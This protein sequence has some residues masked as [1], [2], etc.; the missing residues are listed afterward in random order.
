[1]SRRCCSG[2]RQRLALE[3]HVVGIG[4]RGAGVFGI[5]GRHAAVGLTHQYHV[6]Q[7]RL[8]RGLG[9][10][11]LL[12][13]NREDGG[14]DAAGRPRQA[15][16]VGHSG[17]PS[18]ALKCEHLRWCQCACRR[19]LIEPVLWRP[20]RRS[21]E[22]QI[23][24]GLSRRSSLHLTYLRCVRQDNK[25]GRST[26]DMPAPPSPTARKGNLV[27][28]AGSSTGSASD[29]TIR[30]LSRGAEGPGPRLSFGTCRQR[31]PSS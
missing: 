22:C 17:V 8:R 31:T 20:R 4:R 14:A 24:R 26:H 15:Y 6:L 27:D 7:R 12:G 10:L 23:R 30:G 5:G 21:P 3:R 25:A 9:F 11:L 16:P 2:A 19:E 29:R 28:N 18:G 13:D 1:M